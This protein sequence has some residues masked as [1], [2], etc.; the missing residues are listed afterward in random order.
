MKAIPIKA[1]SIA[2]MLASA[3]ANAEEFEKL[4]PQERAKKLRET[5][6]ILSKLGSDAPT[7]IVVKKK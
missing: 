3:R 6:D 5:A 7:V 2:E 4:T 1:T